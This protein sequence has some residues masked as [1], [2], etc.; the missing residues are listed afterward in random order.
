M[1]SICLTVCA[2][3][4]FIAGCGGGEQTPQQTASA[5]VS[6]V[7][8]AV[9]A[10][11][12]DWG[13]DAAAL[14]ERE[15]GVWAAVYRAVPEP[16]VCYED[17][18]ALTAAALQSCFERQAGQ[19]YAA[20]PD[21]WRKR[22]SGAKADF[23]R[24]ETN[25]DTLRY[26]FP[27]KQAAVYGVPL[28]GLMADVNLQETDTFG[29]VEL[30]L[31][32]S[33][34]LN[35]AKNAFAGRFAVSKKF[36]VSEGREEGLSEFDNAIHDVSEFDSM[37]AALAGKQ[38]LTASDVYVRSWQPRLMQNNADQSLELLCQEVENG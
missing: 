11:A 24:S 32:L 12:D 4:L 33:G 30:V 8:V 34:S 5:A 17:E 2:A 38:G 15:S 36:Y 37:D 6:A 35:E 26:F 28:K 9:A 10:A 16:H 7:A 21:D 29:T 20:L 14:C 1:K 23:Q 27:A 22:L 25:G 3:L 19:F 13:S 31:P 18:N